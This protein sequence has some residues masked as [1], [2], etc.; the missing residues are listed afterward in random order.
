MPATLEI[1]LLV[2]G[3]A[4]PPRASLRVFVR[5]ERVAKGNRPALRD[6]KA[7]TAGVLAIED[8]DSEVRDAFEAQLW[9]RLPSRA[10]TPMRGYYQVGIPAP[11]PHLGIERGEPVGDGHV[12]AFTVKGP[13]TL[14]VEAVE[15]PLKGR[16]IVMDTNGAEK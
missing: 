7:P 3:V 10:K 6:G 12:A 16:A 4:K 5:H 8:L 2:P 13:G 9:S 11:V 1:T 14:R 15:A